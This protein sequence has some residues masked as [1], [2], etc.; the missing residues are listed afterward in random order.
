MPPRVRTVGPTVPVTQKG[1]GKK[2]VAFR[3]S[4]VPPEARIPPPPIPE[5]PPEE[6]PPEQ[7]APE[8]KPPEQKPVEK[9]AP[10]KKART[11]FGEGKTSSGKF[12]DRDRKELG[13]SKFL[14]ISVDNKIMFSKHLAIMLEAGIPL[15]EALEIM[16]EESLSKPIQRILT[17]GIADLS[18]GFTLSSTLEKF[19]RVF[20]PFSVNIVRVGESS[21]TLAKALLYEATELEKSHELAGKVKGALTYPTIIFCGAMGIA[22]Y[23][24][25]YILPKLIPVF[26]AMSVKLPA[27]TK[28]L[29]AA[30][31]FIRTQWLLCIGVLAFIVGM[32][33]VAW[34]IRPIRFALESFILRIP[35]FGRLMRGVQVARATRIFGTLLASGVQI[36]EAIRITSNSTENLVYKRTLERIAVDVERGEEITNQLAKERKLFPAIVTGMVKIGDRT[37]KLSE[38]LIT[39]AEFSER[40]VDNLTKTLATLIEPLTLIL[41]GGLVGFIAI[42]IVSPIYELTSGMS[43]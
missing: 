33:V 35:L 1:A 32:F 28:A 18:N 4:A 8:Q 40:E 7:G 3:A 25:F 19:P 20:A 9:K 13:G 11:K 17:V 24:A 23:L 34:K 26:G 39:A 31:A 2:A 14:N 38:S 15:R 29:M 22:G 42:S 43:K 12:K 6:K 21:G 27:T 16:K 41:V 30:S 37:G 5:A 36:V 10:A